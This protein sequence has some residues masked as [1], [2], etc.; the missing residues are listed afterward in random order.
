[1]TDPTATLEGT[2]QLRLDLAEALRGRGQAQTRLKAAEVELATLR[3]KTRVDGKRISD[4]T[5]ERN[6]L[7]ARV[8]DLKDELEKKRKF[9]KVRPNLCLFI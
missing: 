4:L 2:A 9:L 6:A 5:V 8:R 3:S 7:T 1:V